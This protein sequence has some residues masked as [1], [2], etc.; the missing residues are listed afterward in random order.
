MLVFNLKSKVVGFLW[1]FWWGRVGREERQEER[2]CHSK[3]L[4][5]SLVALYKSTVC[6]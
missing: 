3:C 5:L 1:V 4:Q 6:Y 2:V